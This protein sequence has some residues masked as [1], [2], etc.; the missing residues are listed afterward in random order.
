MKVTLA[1]ACT[2]VAALMLTPSA[3]AGTRTVQVSD[4]SGDLG[5]PVFVRVVDGMI[6]PANFWSGNSPVGQAT[7]LDVLTAW[8][9]AS[10]KA[11][12]YTA[13]MEVSSPVPA[14]GPLPS[15]VTAVWWVWWFYLDT[16]AWAADYRLVVSWD[17]SNSYAYLTNASAH[18]GA[19]FQY[20]MV[21]TY[22]IKETVVTATIDQ[23]LVW[24]AVAWF[25]EVI[26]WNADPAA[27]FEWLPGGGWYA[28]DMTDSPADTMLPWWPLP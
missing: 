10:S 21:G 19:P 23:A 6:N 14:T 5:H 24:N 25:F 1:V 9:T 26:V 4:R 28:A 2:L 12:T 11:D 20:S 7:Y 15:G 8:M 17:G 3:S 22:Q 18:A 27:P 13:G 16:L